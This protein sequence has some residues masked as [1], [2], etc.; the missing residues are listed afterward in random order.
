MFNFR[1]Q[2]RDKLQ[3]KGENGS[4]TNGNGA[5]GKKKQKQK[6]KKKCGFND[7]DSDFHDK[8][9]KIH[10]LLNEQEEE[11]LSEREMKSAR[12]LKAEEMEKARK[13]EELKKKK[14]AAAAKKTAES[15]E[16]KSYFYKAKQEAKNDTLS[17]FLAKEQKEQ[18]EKEKAASKERER[19]LAARKKSQEKSMLT[20]EEEAKID[21][22]VTSKFATSLEEA[23]GSNYNIFDKLNSIED[24][25]ADDLPAKT[26]NNSNSKETTNGSTQI[27]DGKEG[28]ED[29]Q[30]LTL[31][32]ATMA[33]CGVFP[34][35]PLSHISKTLNE[36]CG[37][38][39]LASESLLSYNL[40]EDSADHSAAF[41][42]DDDGFQ[43]VKADSGSGSDEDDEA[44][45]AMVTKLKAL[46]DI[47]D[48]MHLK[49]S[50]RELVEYYYDRNDQSENKTIVDMFQNFDPSLPADSQPKINYAYL[51]L[52]LDDSTGNGSG[53]GA[54]G[55]GVNGK[56]VVGGKVQGSYATAATT[57]KRS[58]NGNG[59]N[60]LPVAAQSKTW[61]LRHY[62][63][64]VKELKVYLNS[65][66]QLRRLKDGLQTPP[67]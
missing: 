67:I 6:G 1:Q 43:P 51:T 10:E 54:K 36:C 21:R 53:S 48:L 42:K 9:R 66:E 7:G 15:R 50:D 61:V 65:N 14:K 11:M 32:P 47:M 34:D 40:L 60:I 18:E 46:D 39:N 17:A 3:G 63:D 22:I 28:E 8:I 45:M 13:A 4:G 62:A 27:N 35:I 56:A 57:A 20:A 58:G 12:E 19:L 41:I 59:A 24:E 55:K 25:E 31:H 2:F 44:L 38:Q 26:T 23:N 64:Q 52:S 16:K 49:E 37:D 33:M 5:N 29:S 30:W